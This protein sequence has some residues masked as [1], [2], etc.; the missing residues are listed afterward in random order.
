VIERAVENIYGP[1]LAPLVL[2]K[3]IDQMPVPVEEENEM[4]A[5]GFEVPI[6][7]QDD[8]QAH[9]QAHMQAM[10][11]QAMMGN[12]RTQKQF[13]VHIFQHV[14]AKAQKA[15]MAAMP[16]QQQQMMQQAGQQ[17]KKPGGSGQGP[18]PGAT[19]QMPRGGQQ[20]PGALGQDQ[21]QKAGDAT[22]FPR[23]MGFGGGLRM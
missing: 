7:K 20:P 4:L 22:A 15:Q 21:M 17:Q 3:P 2:I 11:M 13:Q 23:K 19:P 10:K 6:H 5:E 8:D 12:R 16:P 9:I 14:Q 18:R 1:R